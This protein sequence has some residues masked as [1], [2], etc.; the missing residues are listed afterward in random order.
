MWIVFKASAKVISQ[1]KHLT[2]EEIRDVMTNRIN[3]YSEKYDRIIR[4][5]GLCEKC[6]TRLHNFDPKDNLEDHLIDQDS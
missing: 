5:L 3:K 6:Q 2:D 1:Y 4:H